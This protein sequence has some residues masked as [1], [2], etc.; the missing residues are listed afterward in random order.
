MNK[1]IKKR[2]DI[3]YYPN[4]MIDT[5]YRQ[6]RT[7]PAAAAA[8]AAAAA[9]AAAVVVAVAAA[10]VAVPLFWIYLNFHS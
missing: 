4:A 8:A 10:A 7:K 9:L 6:T 2:E 3:F 1:Y 5:V